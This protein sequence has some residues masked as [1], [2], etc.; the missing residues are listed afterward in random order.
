[1][2]ELPVWARKLRALRE[3]SERLLGWREGLGVGGKEVVEVVGN[4]VLEEEGEEGGGVKEGVEVTGKFEER[5]DAS[6]S[7]KVVK[8]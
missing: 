3:R 2:L 1:M 5:D 8:L 6:S 4:E 7:L